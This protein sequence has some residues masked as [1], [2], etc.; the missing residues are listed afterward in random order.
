M[1]VGGSS[2]GR[3]TGEEW[4]RKNIPRLGICDS[5]VIVASVEVIDQEDQEYQEM[6]KLDVGWAWLW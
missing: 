4:S 2:V 1:N 6:G 3:W 5:G